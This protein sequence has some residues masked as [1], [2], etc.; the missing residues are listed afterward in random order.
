MIAF[1]LLTSIS[2]TVLIVAVA[3]VISLFIEVGNDFK[4]DKEE[5]KRHIENLERFNVKEK[6]E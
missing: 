5:Y 1:I 3:A 6:H 2:V 4:M